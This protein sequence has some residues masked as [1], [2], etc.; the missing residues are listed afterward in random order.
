[1]CFPVYRTVYVFWKN[2]YVFSSCIRPCNCMRFWKNRIRFGCIQER[3]RFSFSVYVLETVYV[4]EKTVYVFLYT[5]TYM[6]FLAVYVFVTVYVS[7]KTVYVLAV[8][9]NFATV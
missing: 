9:G 4:P 3:I 5:G 1:M 7:E 6:F 8:Y 2:V